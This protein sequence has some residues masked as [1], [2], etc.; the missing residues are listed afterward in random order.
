MVLWVGLGILVVS[1][2]TTLS[3]SEEAPL[4]L[5]P[6]ARGGQ[7]GDAEGAVKAEAARLSGTHSPTQIPARERPQAGSGY[8]ISQQPLTSAS[9]SSGPAKQPLSCGDGAQWE[10]PGFGPANPGGFLLCAG[11]QGRHSAGWGSALHGWPCERMHID[12]YC[13]CVFVLRM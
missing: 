2:L 4:D 7:R 5:T 6:E 11:D 1:T 13:P 9:R 8:G 12:A 3:V 10:V